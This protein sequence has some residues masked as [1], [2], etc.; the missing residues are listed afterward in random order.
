MKE[1]A[2]I[3]DML[4]VQQQNDDAVNVYFCVPIEDKEIWAYCS[5][6]EKAFDEFINSLILVRKRI[7]EKVIVQKFNPLQIEGMA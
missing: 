4:I 3:V 6:T 1:D 7:Q 5:F 2:H